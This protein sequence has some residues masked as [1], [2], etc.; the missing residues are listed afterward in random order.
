MIRSRRDRCTVVWYQWANEIGDDA[1]VFGVTMPNLAGLSESRS[2]NISD[3]IVECA[4]NKNLGDGAGTFE[5]VL[6]NTVEWSRFLKAGSWLTI[7]MNSK[8]LGADT[9]KQSP[10]DLLA[11]KIPESIKKAAKLGGFNLNSAAPLPPGPT[12]KELQSLKDSLRGICLI[13]RVALQSFVGGD[14][15]ID[16]NYVVTGK[17]LGVVLEETELWFNFFHYQESA[18]KA[19][20]SNFL[21]QTSRNLTS[22]MDT[23]FD[24]FFK[25]ESI[26]GD[27]EQLGKS[28]ALSLKQWLL[29]KKLLTDLGLRFVGE[30]YFGDI[31]GIKDFQSTLF[32]NNKPDPLAGLQGTAWGKLK[33]LSQPEF[34]ELFLEVDGGAPRVVFRPIPWGI[35]KSNYPNLAK[36][37]TA[38]KDLAGNAVTSV[39][40]TA[41]NVLPGS[42]NAAPRGSSLELGVQDLIDFDVGPDF[43]QRYNHFLVDSNAASAQ[44]NN[45]IS[46]F[47]KEERLSSPFPF[48]NTNSIKRH[49]LRTMHLTIRSYLA[50]KNSFSTGAFRDQPD[51]QFLLEANELIKDYWGQAGDF[52]SGTII[53]K[54]RG[55]VKLGKVLITGEEILGIGAHQFY[56]E[57]YE[58]RFTVDSDGATDWQ[59]VLTVTRGIERADLATNSGFKRKSSRQPKGSFVK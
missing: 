16:Y 56:I 44:Q 13:E 48:R 43:H 35:D 39:L 9:S 12:R 27:Q 55:D 52:L 4:F 59:Q 24:A 20:A 58:D 29:P 47:Q 8:G 38:Y 34:H 33:E 26:F 50:N 10:K 11:E 7:Y 6:K 2:Y 28:L 46:L 25:P 1:S 54:G 15:E 3:H 18:F 17:D 19:L 53:M 49:G 42:T 41:F 36:Y 45:A 40:E 23:W 37:V 14:G 5:I 57:G 30:G 22:L 31:V 32:E 51:K 21:G